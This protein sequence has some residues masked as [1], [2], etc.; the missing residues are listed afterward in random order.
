[1]NEHRDER[2]CYF[3]PGEMVVGVC[4]LCLNERLLVVASKQETNTNYSL[5]PKRVLPKI[6]ALT[7]LLNRSD[8]K[9]HKSE[10]Y[11]STSSHSQEDSFISIKFEENGVASWDKGKISKI[12]Q[13][14]M[15][16]NEISLDKTMTIKSVIEHAKPRATLRWRRRI[17]HLLQLI[18]WKRNVCHVGTKLEGTKVKYGWIRILTKR[19]TKE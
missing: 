3:H 6:F 13:R 11:D 5:T 19:R 9:H 2:R 8:T 1:M 18:K 14:E 17:G 12:S 15:S 4:A 7:N 16:S 10:V